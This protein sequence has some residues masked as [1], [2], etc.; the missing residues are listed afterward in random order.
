MKHK[1]KKVCAGALALTL[2]STAILPHI[3]QK[4]VEAYQSQYG[5]CIDKTG[6]S[7]NHYYH[8]GDVYTNKLKDLNVIIQTSGRDS[9]EYKEALAYNVAMTEQLLGGKENALKVFWAGV[10]TWLTGGVSQY[11]DTREVMYWWQYAIDGYQDSVA[12]NYI[13]P[14]SVYAFHPMT[15]NEIGMMLH[16]NNQVITRDPFLAALTDY[17]HFFANDINAMPQA[18]PRL[19]NAWRESYKNWD[20]NEVGRALWPVDSSG[21]EISLLDGQIPTVD[22]VNQVAL[23][24]ETNESYWFGNVSTSGP[25]GGSSSSG[26]NEEDWED[27]EDEDIEDEDSGSSSS[28]SKKSNPTKEY[29]IDMK[30]IFYNNC[31]TI[32]IWNGEGWISISPLANIRTPFNINGW[33][34]IADVG[35]VN[36]KDH[37]YTKFSWKGEGQPTGLS[38]YFKIPQNAAP[39]AD[40]MGFDSPLEFVAAFMKIYTCDSCSKGVSKGEHQRHIAFNPSVATN[41]YPCFRLGGDDPT[42]IVS[43][44]SLHFDIFRH[45]EDWES[46]YNVQM[47]KYDYETG[48]TLEGSLFELYERF[49]DKDQVNRGHDGAVELYEGI[50]NDSEEEWQSKYTSS[51]VIWDD[52]RL[53]GS[54]QTNS[55]GYISEDVKKGYHYEKTFC[56]GHPAPEF[57]EVPEEEDDPDNSDE[58]EAAQD[59][60][61]R[62]AGLWKEYYDACTKMADEDRPGVHFHWLNEEVNQSVIDEVAESGGEPGETP[63]AG[64]QECPGLDASYDNSGCHQDC[65]DTYDKFIKLKYSYTWIETKA[66]DGYIRHDL[67]TDDVPIEVITTDSSE[68]GANSEFADEYSKDIT[69]NDNPGGQ[70]DNEEDS[71]EEEENETLGFNEILDLFSMTAYA[72]EIETEEKSENGTWNVFDGKELDTIAFFAEAKVIDQANNTDHETNLDDEE[73]DEDFIGDYTIAFENDDISSEQDDITFEEDDLASEVKT[74]TDSNASYTKYKE[75]EKIAE[76]KISF[77]PRRDSIALFTEDEEEGSENSSDSYM[78]I[79]KKAFTNEFTGGKVIEIGPPDNWSHCNDTDGEDN[80]W[81]IY[82]HR[83]PGEIHF[84]KRD[85]D[86]VNKEDTN[87]NAYSDAN[88]D[89]KMEGA[90]YGLFTKND[91]VHP[92]GKTGVVYKKNDLVAIATTDRNGDGSF[93]AFT[94]APGTVYNYE[95]GTTETTSWNASAPKNLYREG[96]KTSAVQPHVVF[97]DGETTEWFCDDYTE[98]TEYKGGLT[99]RLYDN[100]ETN[101]MNCWIGRPLVL[102]EYYIKELSRSEGYELSV[103]GRLNAITNNGADLSVTEEDGSGSVRVSTNMYIQGQESV[104]MPN[105]VFFEV[106]SEGTNENDGYDVVLTKLPEGAK[107]Y[108]H[109][110]TIKTGKFP[111]LDH[112]DYVGKT[113]E[114]GNPVYKKAEHN[115]IPKLKTDGSGELITTETVAEYYANSLKV[116]SNKEFNSEKIDEVLKGTPVINNGIPTYPEFDRMQSEFMMDNGI[117]YHTRFIKYKVEQALRTAKITTPNRRVSGG[118]R[119]STEDVP[120]YSRGIR[121]GDIDTYGVSGVNPGE[122]ATKTVYGPQI[123]KLQINKTNSLGNPVTDGDVIYNIL[124]YYIDNPHWNFGGIEEFEDAGSAYNVYIYA[125]NT[126]IAGSFA[127]LGETKDDTVVYRRLEFVP[128]SI[129]FEP[130]YVFVPYTVNESDDGFGYCSSIDIV[131]AYGS[132]RVNAVLYPDVEIHGDGSLHERKIQIPEY[133]EIGEIILDKNGNPEQELEAVPVYVDKEVSGYEMTWTEVPARYENGKYIIHVDIPVTDAY[134]N[135]LTDEDGSLT[136]EFKAVVPEQEI[137]LTQEDMNN[138]SSFYQYLK[139]GDTMSSGT[140]EVEVKKARAYAYLDYTNE[141]ESNEDTY[142]KEAILSYPGDEYVFQDGDGNP[143]SGTIRNPIKV[144]ERPIRQKVKITKDIQTIPD[145][146]EYLNDTYSEVHKENLSKNNRGSWYERTKDWLA[147]LLGNDIEGQTASKIPEFRFKAYLKSNLE[148]LYRD[149]DGNIT[150]QDRNGNA[151]VPSYQDTNYDGNYDTFVW[152][153]GTSTFDFPEKSIENG[154][155]LESANVQKIYTKVE[156]KASSTTAGDI[157]NNVWAKYAD[158]Q[159]GNTT[160]VGEVEGF[161]TSQDGEN[162]EA[163]NVNASLYSYDDK[164]TNVKQ[165]DKIN[166]NQNQGYTR[167]LETRLRT[168]EDG[169]GK[170]REVEEYNYEKFFDAM[171]AANNDKWDNDMYSSTKNYPGQH[172]FDTFEERYQMDDADPDRTLANVDGVDEDGTAGGDRDNSFKPFQ[173]IREHMFGTTQDAKDDYPATHDNDNLENKIN[174]SDIAHRNAEASNEVRQFAIKWYLDDEVGKLVTNNGYDED[175]AKKGYESYQEEVYDQALEQA[176]I[177][178]YNYLKPFY[179]YDLDT[180]YSVEWDSAENGGSDGDVTTLS[181]DILYEMNGTSQGESKSGYY[182]GVSAY[183]PYG[184]YVLVEQQPFREDLDDF[185]NKHYKTDMPKELILPA[186]YEDGGNVGSPEVFHAFYN[187]N[188]KDTPVDLAKKYMIRFNEEWAE[189]H[190][191]DLRNYVIRAHGYDGDYEVYK[192]GLDVDKL[193]DTIT[194]GSGNY[195]YDGYRITQD[196][197]DPLK[198][199]YNDPLVDTAYDGGNANSHYFADEDNKT[200]KTASGIPYPE[201]AIEK[202]YHFGSIS[203]NAGMANDVLYQLGSSTDDNNPSGFYFKDNVK[204]MTGNQTAYEGKYASMLVPWSVTEPAKSAVYSADDMTGY[205]DRKFRNTFYQTKLRIEKVDS[206]T[207]E[208]LLHDD[209]IFSIYAA[210]RY[211]SRAEIEKAGAPA[212]TEIGDVKFYM[213]DTMITGSKEFLM[214]MGAW[215][216]EPVMRGRAAVGMDELYTGI[217]AAGTPVCLE[218][219]QI[220]M[221]DMLGNKTGQFKVYTTLNDVETVVEENAKGPEDKAYADQNTGYLVTP[222]P[223]GAGVYVIAETKAPNGYAKTRPIAVEIYSD[224]VSYY[225]NGLMDSKVESTIYQG[226]LIEQ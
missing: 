60:N 134:G 36:G 83:T 91:I 198:D 135:T 16:G 221:E 23:D 170:T 171:A 151:Y 72:A 32:E 145:S 209:A 193:I 107:I 96:A 25:G 179:K 111:V 164:N 122:I 46:N 3:G 85:M 177:K 87:Y 89:G 11:G 44:G 5:V 216:I 43:E 175:V 206:E 156:H 12:H 118:T 160:N 47:T 34:V 69:I 70:S 84:N 37:W 98:D 103:N 104:G 214:S 114:N 157:S 77:S 120:I 194:Y 218:E 58:I 162:G 222:Q 109:D 95:K 201:D 116:V 165:T 166:Q 81:R 53:V 219:E 68:A 199:Y 54:Y 8:G 155:S 101:N 131:N 48:K 110:S 14:L 105:E 212:G 22:Q 146:E 126:S 208:Q 192:Y 65:Q 21:H 202:R 57:V 97:N 180:I 144:M 63:D 137:T 184:T 149:N 38:M 30:E 2:F 142:I 41:A 10:A 140:Y 76:L 99:Q 130:Y 132:T 117:T 224:S 119:Y 159:T 74:A 50:E 40:A 154:T 178:A 113:D 100:N 75:A 18:I 51:P 64:S 61:K 174:T 73:F 186:V 211:T 86:L 133:Y 150:W 124:Q 158:P 217:V 203:E 80:M 82:D 15:E 187:Y 172:W 45:T 90:V 28:G 62:L 1:W 168:M 152:Q 204:T 207:G 4:K 6:Y 189:N 129:H 161:S 215:N 33:E 39:A 205:A 195:T 191:D 173:W 79:Y 42:T 102:G 210:S 188:T 226:N 88:A 225:M 121:K 153:S 181:A 147:S 213:E 59:E 136:L 106:T 176:L 141:Q 183:L 26:G 55:D 125:S 24:M 123:I 167:L 29:W 7:P 27:S 66:R 196:I 143:G 94:E 56:D 31:G 190:T 169:A 185:D 78:T 92:D 182:Y 108:R 197:Y 52:F 67:H 128:D 9:K 139:A 17:E 127:V 138:L 112:Y 93:M 148:R 20:T 163:V 35:K 200:F 49:D 19:S 71:G 13:S 223:L 115:G 220:I